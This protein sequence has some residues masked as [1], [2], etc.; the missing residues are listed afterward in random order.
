MLGREVRQKLTGVSEVL[1]V[2]IIVSIAQVMDLVRSSET[3]VNFYQTKCHSIP[4]DSHFVSRNV[5]TH[6]FRHPPI[7]RLCHANKLQY[8]NAH[9]INH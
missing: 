1:A 3:S 9:T 8:N 2:S 7:S 6:E 5:G 4:A